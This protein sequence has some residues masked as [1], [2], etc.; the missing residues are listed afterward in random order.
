MQAFLRWWLMVC[1]MVFGTYGLFQ[2]GKLQYIFEVD[3]SG[4]SVLIFGIFG[5][6]TSWIGWLTYKSNKGIKPTETQIDDAYF[7][8]D[9]MT[10]LGLIGTIVG[11][12]MILG[13][14]FANIDVSDTST[15]EAAIKLMTQGMGTA[16]ITTLVGSC[17][18]LISKLQIHNF[19]GKT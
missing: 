15:I 14:A 11:L 13:P 2:F 1:L 5:M 10:A 9:A 4:I 7:C 18:S 6:L 19:Y 16:L 12:I 17:C 8:A 3:Q